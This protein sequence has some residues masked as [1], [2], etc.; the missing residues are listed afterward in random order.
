MTELLL[1][2]GADVT[3]CMGELTPWDIAKEFGH[4]TICNLLTDHKQAVVTSNASSK[5]EKSDS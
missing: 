5:N 1:K 4:F 2:A 3:L